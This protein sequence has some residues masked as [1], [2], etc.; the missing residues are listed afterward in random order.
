MQQQRDD[1]FS[2][3]LLENVDW[4]D[5]T[6][7]Y[8]Q[9][10]QSVVERDQAVPESNLSSTARESIDHWEEWLHHLQRDRASSPP[11]APPPS[12]ASSRSSTPTLSLSETSEVESFEEFIPPQPPGEPFRPLLVAATIVPRIRAWPWRSRYFL[13][14]ENIRPPFPSPPRPLPSSSSSAPTR[15]CPPPTRPKKGKKTKTLFHYRI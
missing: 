15:T 5:V 11:P 14:K 12:P 4:D 8:E 3:S 9:D 6:W 2:P 1:S 13:E 7:V 10:N